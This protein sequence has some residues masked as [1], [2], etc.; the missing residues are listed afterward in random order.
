M[1]SNHAHRFIFNYHPNFNAPANS[2]ATNFFYPHLPTVELVCVN[3]HPRT[4]AQTTGMPKSTASAWKLNDPFK[5]AFAEYI[6]H[7]LDTSTDAVLGND[8]SV[9]EDAAS[10]ASHPVGQLASLNASELPANLPHLYLFNVIVALE[11][12]P[13]EQYLRQLRWGFK[14]ASDFLYD[15]TDGTMAF[16][17]V[18]FVDQTFLNHADIQITTSN[19]IMPRS[20]V[21]G[22]LIEDKYMPIRIGRGVWQ[23][24]DQTMIAWDE[25]SGYRT[26]VHEWAHYAL[27][28]RDEYLQ[29]VKDA[30]AINGTKYDLVLPENHANTSLMSNPI[31]SSELPLATIGDDKDRIAQFYSWLAKKPAVIAAVRNPGPG[32]LPLPLPTFTSQIQPSEQVMML[33]LPAH[34]NMTQATQIYVIAPKTGKHNGD[35]KDSPSADND[36]KK[37][38][39]KQIFAQGSFDRETAADEFQLLGAKQGDMVVMLVQNADG[40]TSVWQGTCGAREAT[41]SKQRTVNYPADFAVVPTQNVLKNHNASKVTHVEVEVRAQKGSY[42]LTLDAIGFEAIK[43]NG[44]SHKAPLDGLVVVHEGDNIHAV[45]DYSQGGGPATTIPVG[46]GL[47]TAG[48]ANGEALIFFKS[49]ATGADYVVKAQQHDHIHIVTTNLEAMQ[50]TGNGITLVSDIFCV[51]SNAALPSEIHPTL[52]LLHKQRGTSKGVAIC[53][54]NNGTWQK[55]VTYTDPDAN[56]VATTLCHADSAGS[57][58][59]CNAKERLEYYALC[60]A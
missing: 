52:V 36:S 57:L 21:G 47:L 19:R 50:T 31:G 15:A 53:R 51:A 43:V 8:P 22:L 29:R 32:E 39:I 9:L 35:D 5:V 37:L 3:E 13:N 11:W 34:V 59:N 33:K 23:R 27:F 16:G 17:Q 46:G 10:H 58:I 54:L 60:V 56:Y 12:T 28:Q 48:S 49:D 2:D 4:K 44:K 14:R 30:L 20:W 24:N 38:R 25:P 45:L 6:V 7:R 41:L 42:D 55:L 26:I 40:T 18:V 1:S